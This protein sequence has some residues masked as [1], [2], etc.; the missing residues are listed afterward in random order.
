MGVFF[1]FIQNQYCLGFIVLHFL[2]VRKGWRNYILSN[3]LSHAG[4]IVGN[5]FIFILI[6]ISH[7]N[8]LLPRDVQFLYRIEIQIEWGFFS[9][10]FQ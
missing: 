10:G 1:L 7:D 5:S 8:F 2:F 6:H 9:K 3:F 4:I